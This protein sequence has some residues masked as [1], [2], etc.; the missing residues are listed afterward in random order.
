METSDQIDRYLQGLMPE[1]ERRR[2]EAM[3][4]ENPHLAGSV[5]LRQELI[6]F[7][8]EH[9][10]QIDAVIQQEEAFM[11]DMLLNE[12]SMPENRELVDTLRNILSYVA[13]HADSKAIQWLKTEAIFYPE[14]V[15]EMLTSTNINKFKDHNLDAKEIEI[16]QQRVLD[17][18][19][20]FLS[21]DSTVDDYLYKKHS[22]EASLKHTEIPL[23]EVSS[24]KG[25]S[26]ARKPRSFK[27]T[28]FWL[29]SI[30][31]T[32]V[33]LIS[34]T[35]IWILLLSKSSNDSL[36]ASYYEPLQAP[37]EMR[38]VQA[39]ENDPFSQAV[40]FY[41]AKDF[42]AAY[43]TFSSIPANDMNYVPACLFGGISAME[44]GQYEKAITELNK[45]GGIGETT[46]QGD[47]QWYLALCY[48]K[49]GNENAARTILTDLAQN[50]YYSSQAVNLLAD[51]ED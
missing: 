18:F 31:A 5:K 29:F 37:T 11:D 3:L 15:D 50:S 42:E 20:I 7:G 27:I 33:V 6:S 47:F 2:F 30:A 39:S 40:D 13:D 51:M 23:T 43:S 48:L 41:A 14:L 26:K 4:K 16:L 10:E 22:E 28:R 49:L 1:E 46:L 17:V 34:C 45:V 12:W 19:E 38:G 44:T 8:T 9:S 35:L 36:Y 24:K 32:I 21:I 25:N